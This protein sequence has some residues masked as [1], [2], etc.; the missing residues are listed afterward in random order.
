MEPKEDERVSHGHASRFLG[1]IAASSS[2]GIDCERSFARAPRS[3]FF[4]AALRSALL[5]LM[6]AIHLSS[7][8]VP[9]VALWWYFSALLM[10]P[11]RFGEE[12][13]AGRA[14]KR[15]PMLHAELENI[16]AGGA[17]A[18]LRTHRSWWT[19]SGSLRASPCVWLVGRS[20]C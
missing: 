2:S 7:K 10:L 16:C 3:I 6:R 20:V 17:Q 14:A 1:L 19:A 9:L 11:W 5:R 18:G 8:E 12:H 15:R 13:D 4:S